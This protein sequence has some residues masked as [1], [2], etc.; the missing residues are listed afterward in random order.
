MPTD[1]ATNKALRLLLLNIFAIFIAVQSQSA[2]IDT[3]HFH[4]DRQNKLILV[5]ADIDT[6]NA[7]FADAQQS[8]S[9]GNSVYFFSA[10]VPL[11]ETGIAY[12]VTDSSNK[13]FDLYFTRLPVTHISASDSIGLTSKTSAHFR[14]IESDGTVTESKMGIE[15]QGASSQGFPKKS[16][17]I[18]FWDDLVAGLT[19]NISLLG[20]RSDDDW[21]LKAMYNEPLRL[22]N[23]V[24]S[25][26]WRK[27]DTLSYSSR[28]PNATNG[29]NL[30]YTELFFNEAYQ[31]LYALT[32]RIDRK[33][34]KLEKYKNEL[35]S[36]ELYKA[37]GWQIT[38][39]DSLPPFDNNELLWG[40]FL[41]KYPEE[42]IDWTNLHEFADFVINAGITEFYEDYRSRFSLSNAV[43]YFI[44]LNLLK[45]EDNTGKNTFIARYAEGEPY[46]YVP[47]DL[48]G[49]F[50]MN[51]EGKRIN[52]TDGILTNGLY[53]RLLWDNSENGFNAQLK[54]RWHNLR[55]SSI[56]LENLTESFGVQHR[57]LEDNGVYQ[58][59]RR[60]WPGCEQLDNNNLAYTMDWIQER[61]RYLDK[62]FINPR[63][64]TNTLEQTY[65]EKTICKIFIDPSQ[66]QLKLV[67]N[68]QTYS[69]EKIS[70][71]NL[72]GQKMH[73][74]QAVSSEDNIDISGLDNG[75]YIV[76]A[77]LNNGH[78]HIEKV[79]LSK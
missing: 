1:T 8:I 47:W 63:L 52:D 74:S 10:P 2:D 53:D 66:L 38:R 6:L 45:A 30:Q 32:E 50:G 79:M 75:V 46:F 37:V 35:I 60:T 20:M 59:E 29:I 3:V 65:T 22:R 64:I 26:L 40:E 69:L 39:F 18:E 44:F 67:T 15:Y 71:I 62:K 70:V 73:V 34:L 13:R 27:I 72:S 23:K 68:D 78:Q 24:S 11:F 76:L 61:L 41:Y 31:G 9:S 17:R 5:N 28:E 16:F 56:T 33:Q 7:Q 55:R 51:W 14:L 58:R 4:I 57:Y 36:G 25:E 48:D 77:E 54:T 49:V 43:N 19:K 21:N 42:K 12:S